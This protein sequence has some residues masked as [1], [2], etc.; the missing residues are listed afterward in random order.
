VKLAKTVVC[1]LLDSGPRLLVLAFLGGMACVAQTAAPLPQAPS[2]ILAAQKRAAAASLGIVSGDVTDE[3]GEA[4]RGA[5]VTLTTGGGKDVRKTIASGNGTFQFTGVPAGAFS[6]TATAP[7]MAK[8]VQSGSLLPGEHFD[9]PEIKLAVSEVTMEVDALS[10]HEEAEQEVHVEEHQRLIGVVPNFYVVYNWDAAPL[11]T[12]EKYKLA[13][14]N[15]IDP[16]NTGINA[17]IAGIQ[18][19]EN[20]FVG[21]GRGWAGYARRFGANEGDLIVG[22]FVG[23]AV[24][25]S[26]L[27]QDPRYFYMGKGT[28]VHR[29]LYA[30]ASAVICKGDNGKWQPNYSAIGGDVAAGAIANT[31]YPAS[32]KN[33]ASVVIEQGLI[34]ALSDGLGNVVQE[35]LFK[36]VTRHAPVYSSTTP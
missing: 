4:I 22:T 32:D 14:M 26:I 17:G 13:W 18:Y 15:A 29:L 1:R 5:Q 9:L 8:G 27:H 2:S 7:D 21:Y 3:D 16:V 10:P 36:K 28:V 33:G 11:D 20:D 24:L 6:V 12:K 34:G 35:F 31:Y 19:S 23:G 30:L 25:P